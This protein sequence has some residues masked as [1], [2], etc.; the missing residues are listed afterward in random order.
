[1]RTI[2]QNK[3]LYLFI[4]PVVVSGCL[5]GGKFTKPTVSQTPAQYSQPTF[6][7]DSIT[8]IQWTELYKDP[9]LQQFIRATLDSNRNL[10]AAAA[11]I[12][13]SREIAGIVKANLYPA[14]GYQALAGGGKAG[15]EAEKV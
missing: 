6:P 13:E 3:Y 5:V 7:G 10:L 15:T 12:E 9:A 8:T 4:L 2:F 14:F 1:M 11:R